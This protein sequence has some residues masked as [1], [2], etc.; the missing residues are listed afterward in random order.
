[1]KAKAVVKEVLK[2]VKRGEKAYLPPEGAQPVEEFNIELTYRCNQRCVMCDVWR[3]H[4]K[5]PAAVRE[6]LTLEEIKDLVLG[7]RYLE[8]L[9]VAVLSGGEPFL[10]TDLAEICG[11][12][13]ENFPG[14]EVGILTNAYNRELI[15][16]TLRTIDDRWGT[17][18]LWLG[19]SLDGTGEVH[20]RIRGCPGAF[21]ALELTLDQ[22]REEFLHLPLSFN[23]TLTPLN[24]Q[25][26]LPAFYFARQRGSHFSA[27]F[28]IPW[29]GATTFSWKKGEMKQ[30]T[31]DVRTIIQELVDEKEASSG[32]E[33]LFRDTGFLSSLFYWQGLLEYGKKPR[34]LF[35]FCK[36]GN[37]FVM[38]S[39]RG[40]LYLCPRFKYRVLGNIREK[41]FDRIWESPGVEEFR[42]RIA[43][44]DCHCWL[45]CMVYSF[46]GQS[47]EAKRER[48]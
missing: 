25:E 9:K 44:G 37:N 31:T 1:M 24:Y 30:L 15:L 17:S 12:F 28:P 32:R 40:D 45:N 19:M 4:L 2:R 22:V 23:F 5:D 3:R 42:E 48:T 33:S 8:G 14:L 36:A 26:L 21:E 6:E 29:K 27:Q 41:K 47:I 7:S 35:S 39:P 46:A 13:L 18:R 20:D 38:F 10:R 16:K 11:L 43:R 34:R